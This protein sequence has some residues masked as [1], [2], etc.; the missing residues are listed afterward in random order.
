MKR[1]ISTT[2]KNTAQKRVRPNQPTE[3]YPRPSPE[4]V[5]ARRAARKAAKLR[6]K[7]YDPKTGYRLVQKK[8]PDCQ[9]FAMRTWYCGEHFHGWQKLHKSNNSPDA[10]RTVEQTLETCLRPYF[11]QKVKFVPSG[12]T[13]AKV[14]ARNQM[15]QFDVCS[16][17]L[18]EKLKGSGDD[19]VGGGVVG[20]EVGGRNGRNGSITS[21]TT[22]TSSTSTSSSS[23]SVQTSSNSNSNS[24]QSQKQGKDDNHKTQ[25]ANASLLPVNIES[26]LQ[27]NFNLLLPEDIRILKVMRV[28]STFNVM[29]PTWKRYHYVYPASVD[30]LTKYMRFSLS[31]T[32]AT[33]TVTTTASKPIPPTTA[34]G[35]PVPPVPLVPPVLP[36]P[37]ILPLPH[38]PSLELMQQA[39]ALLLGTHDFGSYQSKNGRS[40]TVR[41]LYECTVT[42]DEETQEY[43]LSVASNGF[44]MH[45]VRIVAGTMM[46]VGVGLRSLKEMEQS[47]QSIGR[48]SAGTKFPGKHLYLDWV[49]YDSK[50]ANDNESKGTRQTE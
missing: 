36:V 44:L 23:S 21:T 4:V 45:M 30:T 14:N 27:H 1:F 6:N 48:S 46:E 11:L 3:A 28:P 41:T 31:A 5:A 38:A 37:P 22:T 17:L 2:T 19:G 8:A 18:V 35:T 32:P 50:H 33:T 39:C 26:V 42:R 15:V 49:E 13:D 10:L 24:K 43:V 9:R 7:H 25:G 47:L 34:T 40:T 20:G 16:R 12:R 29:R